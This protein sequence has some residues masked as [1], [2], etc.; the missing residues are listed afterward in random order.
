[1]KYI[2]EYGT[3][4]TLYVISG[5]YINEYGTNRTIYVISGK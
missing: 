4:R 2:N 1:M 3:N 5:K